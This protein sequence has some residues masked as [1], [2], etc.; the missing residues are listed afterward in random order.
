MSIIHEIQIE[1]IMDQA[2][3]IIDDHFNE[4]NI[5]EISEL[6]EIDN[7]AKEALGL[8]T[9]VFDFEPEEIV[10][11]FKKAN[12]L[13]TQTVPQQNKRDWRIL[14]NR[15]KKSVETNNHIIAQYENK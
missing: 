12:A 15:I 10:E 11:R 7:Q 1:N 13:I 2:H 5:N 6:R 4:L 3:C 14:R 8:V 9:E